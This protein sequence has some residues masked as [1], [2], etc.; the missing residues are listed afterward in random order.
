MCSAAIAGVWVAGIGTAASLYQ[1]MQ[2]MALSVEMATQQ[3]DL[4]FRQAQQQQNFQ[5][6]ATIQKHIGD[7]K[8]QQAASLAAEKAFFYGDQ[9]ANASYVSQ[10]EKFK[11]IQTK[12]AFKAQEIYA[13]SIG[14]KGRILASG[15]TGQSI[16][17]LALNEERL[18]GFALAEQN[19]TVRSAEMA[20][21]NSMEGTR[22]KALSN[23][24]TIASK[25][26]TPVMAPTLAPKPIGI[27]EDLGLGIPSYNWA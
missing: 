2:N 15:A 26:P 9:A 1:G 21:G 20:L 6:K 18:A 23:I 25:T 8:A 27:G 3:Q 22:L 24:N 4:A 5:N 12:A 11:E 19:A 7:V 17:L 14:G 16:G 13:K 10:Q